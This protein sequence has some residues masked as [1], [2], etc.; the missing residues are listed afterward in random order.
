MATPRRRSTAAE[1]CEVVAAR[2][3]INYD[4]DIIAVWRRRAPAFPRRA[5][6]RVGSMWLYDPDVVIAWMV[7]TGRTRAKRKGR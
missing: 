6:E 5:G 3:G 1:I 4:P 2:Y 7:A